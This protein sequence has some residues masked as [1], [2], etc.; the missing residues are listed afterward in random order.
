MHCSELPG[1]LDNTEQFRF[2]RRVSLRDWEENALDFYNNHSLPHYSNYPEGPSSP[3]TPVSGMENSLGLHQYI[4]PSSA[5]PLGEYHYLPL[6][7]ESIPGMKLEDHSCNAAYSQQHSDSAYY[8]D[9][10]IPQLD[11]TNYSDEQYVYEDLPQREVQQ[12]SGSSS[13][14]PTFG[15]ACKPF[16]LKIAFLLS[17]PELYGDVARWE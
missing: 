1:N 4:P 11:H 2:G 9:G 6:P 17:Q 7:T 16:I 12:E 10:S 3:V 5:S 8:S 15:G 13:P 14:E